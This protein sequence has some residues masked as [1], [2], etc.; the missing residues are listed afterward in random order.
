VR[1]VQRH[2]LGIDRVERVAEDG[3]RGQR[4]DQLVEERQV[5]VADR[6]ARGA[7]AL[8]ALDFLTALAERQEQGEE[9]RAQQ[10]PRRGL[11]ADHH[12]AR[13]HADLEA[14]RDAQAIDDHDPLHPERVAEVEREVCDRPGHE[15]DAAALRAQ[16]GRP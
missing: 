10:D 3:E 15:R 11:R 13:V 2:R 5:V 16:S 6:R 9:E 7:R 4:R 14:Q 8:G 12:R 1:A